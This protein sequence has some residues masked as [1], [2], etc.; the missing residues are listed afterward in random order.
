MGAGDGELIVKKGIRFALADFEVGGGIFIHDQL[1]CFR[2]ESFR[3]EVTTG[4]TFGHESAV[5]AVKVVGLKECW[6]LTREK[7]ETDSGV[8]LGKGDDFGALGGNS[9]GGENQIDLFR[10]ESGDESVEGDVFDLKGAM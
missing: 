7:S 9:E 6:I 10:D 2:E 4:A 8:G 3:G 1:F 5:G